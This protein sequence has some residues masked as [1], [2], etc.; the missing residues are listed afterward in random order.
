MHL[1]F[2]LTFFKKTTWKVVKAD[3]SVHLPAPLLFNL[4]H[5]NGWSLME[6]EL[7]AYLEEHSPPVHDMEGTE[8]SG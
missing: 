5:R 3:L 1:I 7:N 2:E 8:E 4:D 6:N